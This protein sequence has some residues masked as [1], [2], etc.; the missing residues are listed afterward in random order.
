MATRTVS[1]AAQLTAAFAAA[2]SGD[3]IVLNAGNY[4]AVELKNHGFSGTVTI[5]SAAPGRA[6]VG[7]LNLQNVSNVKFEGLRFDY[8]MDASKQGAQPFKVT[9]SSKVTF[10]KS[11]FDGDLAGGYA[12]GTGLHVTNSS[13]VTLE[14]SEITGF[15]RGTDFYNVTGLAVRNNELSALSGDGITFAQ[16]TGARIEGNYIHHM[17]GNP[18]SGYHKDLIQ[19]WTE[20][21]SRPSTDVVIR[22]NALHTGDGSTQSIFLG[23]SVAGMYWR[24]VTIEGNTVVA[25][26]VH[27]IYVARANGL[28]IRGNTVVQDMTTGLQRP[29]QHA[30]HRRDHRTRAA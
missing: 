6:V 19:G 27:G 8:E 11:T 24:N 13:Q 21:T 15:H 26:H 25:G 16:L 1:N 20:G 10:S 3:R 7:N 28:A 9:N 17:R 23:N 29:D 5:A 30:A 4:G 22:G 18:R 14:S 12:F 2:H